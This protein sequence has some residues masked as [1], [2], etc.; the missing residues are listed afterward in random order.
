MILPEGGGKAVYYRRPSKIGETLEDP[1]NLQ[2]WYARMTLV[3]AA[4]RTDVTTRAGTMHPDN[5]R[6]DLDSLVETC[7]TTAQ[8]DAAA[9]LGSAFHAAAEHVDLGGDLSMVPAGLRD[10]VAAYHAA[11]QHLDMIAVERF[12]VTDEVKC[13]GTADRLVA[14]DGRLIVADIKT[15]RWFPRF[16]MTSAAV[17]MSIY[18]HGRLYDHT[19]GDRTTLPVDVTTGLLIHSPLDGDPRTT[20]YEVDLTRAWEM[21]QT[22]IEVLRWRN[23]G[24]SLWNEVAY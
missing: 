4:H 7:V 24:D 1:S 16:G 23:T 3:G 5:D 22:A 17:Q 20:L 2:R 11:V 12:L 15:G 10:H 14:H 8:S 18:A 19:N 13:A 6:T 9:N 21:A